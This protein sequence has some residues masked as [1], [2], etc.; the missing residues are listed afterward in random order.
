MHIGREMYI[1]IECSFVVVPAYPFRR[2]QAVPMSE[3]VVEGR[4]KGGKNKDP[5][6][7]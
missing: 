6:H 7:Y 3:T 2:T 4:E 1:V 5:K